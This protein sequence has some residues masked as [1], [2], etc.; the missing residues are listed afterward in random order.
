[1]P[2]ID[3]AALSEVRILAAYVVFLASYVV[4]ALGKFPGL[5][6]DRTAAAIIGAVGMVAFR[7][8]RAGEAL[9]YIDF[10]TIVLLFR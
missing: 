4:F 9:R 5:K 8:V 1:M 7:I 2:A 3:P 6:I 10:P